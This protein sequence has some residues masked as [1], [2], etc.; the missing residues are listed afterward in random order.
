LQM[1]RTRYDEKTAWEILGDFQE[2]GVIRIME[3]TEVYA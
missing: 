1:C 2:I 3:N